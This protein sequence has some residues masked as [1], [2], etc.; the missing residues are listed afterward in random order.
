MAVKAF[1]IP[2]EVPQRSGKKLKLNFTLM[3]FFETLGTVRFKEIYATE[4]ITNY[5]LLKV[6]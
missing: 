4:T 3:K 2:L 1:I 6:P 5:H